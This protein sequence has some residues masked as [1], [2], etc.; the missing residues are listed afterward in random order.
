MRS[1]CRLPQVLGTDPAGDAAVLAAQTDG[2][3]PAHATNR[4]RLTFYHGYHVRRRAGTRTAEEHATH[5]APHTR[6]SVAI[7]L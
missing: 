5:A 3:I 6:V 2:A 4:V 7:A 1:P